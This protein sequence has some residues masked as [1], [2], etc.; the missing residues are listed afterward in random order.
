VQKRGAGVEGGKT[1]AE[2]ETIPSLLPICD[3]LGNVFKADLDA[4]ADAKARAALNNCE[5]RTARSNKIERSYV[6]RT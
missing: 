1:A 3:S 4:D 2:I 6:A 5:K